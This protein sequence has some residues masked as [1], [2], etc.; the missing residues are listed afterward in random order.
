MK[1]FLATLLTLTMLGSVSVPA[2]AAEQ[3]AD[4]TKFPGGEIVR[5]QRQRQHHLSRRR[6]QHPL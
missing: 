1:K 2:L 6:S 4:G 5:H 3:P